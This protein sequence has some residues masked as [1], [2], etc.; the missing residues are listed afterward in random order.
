MLSG[1]EHFASGLQ[2]MLDRDK[3]GYLTRK[4]VVL[5]RSQTCCCASSSI[6]HETG[7]AAGALL[8]K[9]C[10]GFESRLAE[11]L[12]HMSWVISCCCW[13]QKLTVPHT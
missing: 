7:F 10:S 5:R 12:S 2:E 6:R 11:A 8:C 3:D 1:L 9:H 4:E 13:A